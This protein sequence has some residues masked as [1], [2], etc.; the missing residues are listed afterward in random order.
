[1]SNWRTHAVK[2]WLGNRGHVSIGF[3]VTPFQ[4][5]LFKWWGWGWGELQI[6]PVSLSV[7]WPYDD[8]DRA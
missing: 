2:A 1:M 7:G 5:R 8:G 3:T 4:W 6:G